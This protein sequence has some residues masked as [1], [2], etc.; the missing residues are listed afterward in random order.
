MNHQTDSDLR[1]PL[2]LQGGTFQA[3]ILHP[4][5]ADERKHVICKGHVQT[6]PLSSLADLPA[7]LEG[8]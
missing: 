1:K 5:Y 7:A 8:Q 6:L 4:L 2:T 3:T